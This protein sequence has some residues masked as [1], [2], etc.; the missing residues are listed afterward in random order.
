MQDPDTFRFLEGKTYRL[1]VAIDL[2]GLSKNVQLHRRT[3]SSEI[4]RL[5][6]PFR[7]ALGTFFDM[8]SK[9]RSNM[10][11][12]VTLSVLSKRWTPCSGIVTTHWMLDFDH[13]CSVD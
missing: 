4:G 9:W 1:L 10:S 12:I 13:L 7:T 3:H 2:L 8:F 5:A 11:G 6:G